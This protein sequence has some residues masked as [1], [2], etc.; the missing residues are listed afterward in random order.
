MTM[1]RTIYFLVIMFG[2]LL[3]HYAYFPGLMAN[4]S[5]TQFH[6]AQT[7]QFDDWHP[8]ILPL[9]WSLTH[10]IVPGPEGFFLLLLILYWGGFFLVGL[11]VIDELGTR[12]TDYIK[13]VL[14]CILPFSPF[15]LN[16]SGTIW[17]DVLVFGCF[18]VALG[19]ILLQPTGSRILSWRSA[20]I[21]GLLV[22]GSLA[23]HNSFVAAVPLLVLHLWPQAPERRL[24]RVVLGRGLIATA[25]T[26]A[27]VFG[28]DK[29]LDTFVVHSAKKHMENEIFLFD[30]VGISHRINQNLVPGLW[31]DDETKQILTTCYAPMHWDPLSP[32]GECHFVFDRLW[33]SGTWQK[34]LLPRWARAVVSY[35]REYLAH[36]LDYTRTL[37]WPQTTFT[38]EPNRESFEFG[39]AQNG[40]FKFIASVIIFIGVHF[41]I[42]VLVTDAFWIAL[43]FASS[44]TMFI[45]YL[46][47]PHAYYRG[48]L[49][50]LS[51]AFY[52]VPLAVVGPGGDYRYV[53]WAAGAT[54]IAALLAP[55][56]HQSAAP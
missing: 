1:R 29:A 38:L 45:L 22:I 10:K 56:R 12:L 48:L 13:Y 55:Q 42:Y 33:D 21:W 51:A 7:F 53:Y 4:D 52:A 49:V 8:P 19:L 50:A 2:A 36:R 20:M 15:L 24:L 3:T 26:V 31:S 17:K 25:L 32:W 34:G 11:A 14:L 30:L 39:F 40:V 16:I 44:V 47:R 6:Q 18:V 41:P 43:S 5:S 54:C 9:I 35:P 27:A 37:L 23:R 28:V 46:K